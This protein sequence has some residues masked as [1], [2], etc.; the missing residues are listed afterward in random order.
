[1]RQDN[2]VIKNGFRS[3]VSTLVRERFNGSSTRRFAAFGLVAVAGVGAL[4]STT[5]GAASPDTTKAAEVVAAAS[6]SAERTTDNAAS[7]GAAK[8]PAT[9]SAK[10]AATIAPKKAT[11]PAKAKPVA[12]YNQTQMDNAALIVKAGQE[13]GVSKQAQI[14][15]VAT[16]MQE[17]TLYNRA[18]YVVPE[19]LKY[20]HQGTGAD[21]DSVGLFQQRYTTGWG[22]VKQIMNPKESAKS[23][24]RALLQVDGWQNMP[25]TVAAQT[26][27]GS[28]FPD[29]YA[30]HQGN[31][32]AV[33]NSVLA[34]QK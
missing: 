19:S 31:A 13:L 33:V 8:T 34:A 16:A 7:R 2:D 14:I 22:T 32:T 5:A 30:K 17:S 24:Y 1:M 10:K 11:T 4:L 9:Q 3:H 23:F 18:S 26:V 21:Y 27:Q 29:H 25:L 28:A 15:A 12:G 6:S 20:P